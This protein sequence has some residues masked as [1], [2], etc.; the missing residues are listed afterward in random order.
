MADPQERW[1]RRLLRL[2]PEDFRREFGEQMAADFADERADAGRAGRGPTTRLWVRTIAG[3]ARTGPREH[4]VQ[5]AQDARHGVRLARRH[6]ISTTAA[7]LVL[8][9]GIAVLTAS[10]AIVD[11]FMWRP[12]PFGN[13]EALVHVWSTDRA[14][15][16]SS[17]RSTLPAFEVWS[18]A[19]SIESI[20]AFNYTGAELAGEGEAAERIDVALVSANAFDVLDVAPVMGR[21]FM[22]GEDRAGAAPVVIL[23]HGYWQSRYGG[24]GDIVGRTIRLDGA[25]RTIV[26]VMPESFVFPL[27]LTKLWMPYAFSPA[28]YPRDRQTLQLVARLAPGVTPVQAED[29]LSAMLEADLRAHGEDV[30]GRAR[31]Q[32][33]RGALNFA[34]QGFQIAGPVLLMAGALILL[35]AC[36]NVSSVLLG[37]AMARA[38]E[39]SVRSA[40]GA[41][42]FRLFRQFVLESAG[43]MVASTGLGLLLTSLWLNQVSTLL[44]L[45]LYR[46]GAIGIDARAAAVAIVASAFAVLLAALVPARRFGRVDPVTAM[47]AEGTST[48]GSRG[49]RRM[50]HALLAVQVT[51]S[52][53][54]VA[55][56]FVAIRVVG[57]LADR[58][59]GF[60]SRGVL[61]SLFVLT[62]AR[63]ETADDVRAFHARLLEELATAPAVTGS[64]TV[65]HLPLNH[66]TNPMTVSV[67]G[68]ASSEADRPTAIRVVVSD[69]YFDTMSIPIRE[70]RAFDSRESGG[71]GAVVVNQALAD[72]HWPGAS[73]IGRTLT[74]GDEPG[75]TVVG[76][77]GNARQ[78]DLAGQD[79]AVA[80]RPSRQVPLRAARVI[81]RAS[82]P[83]AV[84]PVVR[85][86]VARI[87]PNLPL[88]EV[89]TLEE[90]VQTFLLPQRAMGISM[91]AMGLAGLLLT[92][93][94]L[95]GLLDVLVGERRKEI[96]LRRALGANAGEV[97]AAVVRRVLV[98]TAIG[99]IG[100]VGLAA[101]LSRALAGV[102]PGARALDP[103]AFA[104]TLLV[105]LLVVAVAAFVPAR[106]AARVN[107]L[108][109]LRS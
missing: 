61:T 72:R 6:P 104:W 73:P 1:F 15:R 52:V 78:A 22:P 54:L 70:G 32:D 71:P 47:R 64:A 14:T 30:R 17:V 59:T 28:R 56:S 91:S 41:S 67:P 77:A 2:V 65:D 34:D 83:L 9:L 99:L 19:R 92:A 8:A 39:V 43:L 74:L 46:V 48:T 66:E 69:G 81:V 53:A 40:I 3:F 36:A 100:G 89:R 7:A 58:P 21:A 31:I 42:R 79:E 88:V 60:E 82:D 106:R 29:E 26:G 107:P 38:R 49:A 10:F 108:E 25:T 27:P 37:R 4:L 101:V 85:A 16:E 18:A 20:A 97:V 109:T 57:T 50:Q 102:L 105:V 62:P 23:S 94:G 45:D 35:A 63:Y 24:A 68:D 11:A 95:F 80:Y 44:P 51:L 76:V 84:T 90:V 87:D 55:T 75:L 13:P 96:G 103:I 33:L 98:V 12:L 5:C 93:I 86:A